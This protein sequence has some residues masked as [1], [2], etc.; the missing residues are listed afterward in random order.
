VEVAREGQTRELN[1]LRG[2]KGPVS[3]LVFSPDGKHLVSGGQDKTV[4]VWD[5]ETGRQLFT[6]AE[7]KGPVTS[8]AISADGKSLASTSQDK[9]VKLWNMET[10]KCSRTRLHSYQVDWVALNPNGKSVASGSNNP[11]S[12]LWNK[13]GTPGGLTSNMMIW[14]AATGDIIDRNG[15]IPGGARTALYSTDGTCLYTI[16]RE[17]KLT[18]W[19]TTRKKPRLSLRAPGGPGNPPSVALSP[20]GLRLACA[21]GTTV[22]VWDE[23]AGTVL[24]KK[25][26]PCLSVA[27]HRDGLRL[28]GFTD[29]WRKNV[30]VWDVLTGKETHVFS[31]QTRGVRRA[32]FTADG[33]RLATASE[34]G[35]VKIWQLTEQ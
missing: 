33:T 11:P 14:N 34:D 23:R 28:F 35:T 5:S 15:I 20:D 10:G 24:F 29:S 16:G 30:I 17:G 6:L 25:N 7:H 18:A 2:H 26:M 3:G 32:A 19:D 9:T 31:L 12:Q 8:L 1:T 27:F 4:R 21:S 22:N 13:N